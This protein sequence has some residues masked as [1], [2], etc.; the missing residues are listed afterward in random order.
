MVLTAPGIEKAGAPDQD[1]SSIPVPP[2]R[3][4]LAVRMVLLFL[5]DDERLRPTA[6]PHESGKRLALYLVHLPN[7][8]HKRPRLGA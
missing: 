3:D 6:P 4:L 8:A 5:V 1:H 7:V 2:T